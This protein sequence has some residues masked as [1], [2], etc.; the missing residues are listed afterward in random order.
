MQL[1]VLAVADQVSPFLYDYFE[2]DRWRHIDLVLS[3]GDLPPEYLGFLCTSLGVPV[4]YVRGNHDAGYES[5][6]Y[7]GCDNVHGR[8]VQRRG[9]RIA[10]FEGCRRYNRGSCQYSEDEMQRVV[11][12]SRLKAFLHGTP[13]LVLSHA[14]PS[15]CH[16]GQDPCH[17]GFACFRQLIDLWRPAFFVHGHTHNYSGGAA[18]TRVDHTVVVNAYPYRVLT[19]PVS[20]RLRGPAVVAP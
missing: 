14:P 1:H 6:R 9:L 16:D 11:R 18:M 20:E 2:P 3:C 12:R 17:Q 5:D 15:G 10:G 8:I 13:D 19:V 7:D 4:L